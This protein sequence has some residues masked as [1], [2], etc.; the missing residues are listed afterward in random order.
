MPMR[1]RIPGRG[2]AT[3][4]L[5]VLIL[6]ASS[7]ATGLSP[8]D[9]PV[10]PPSHAAAKDGKKNERAKS[11][12]NN[13]QGKTDGKKKGKDKPRRG[14]RAK[15]SLDAERIAAENAQS[16]EAMECGGDLIA[17]R[18]DDRVYC[19]HGEDEAPPA[20]DA[21]TGEGTAGAAIAAESSAPAPRALCLDD[22]ISGPRIQ[23]IYVHR[24]DRPNRLQELLPT[25]RRLAAEMDLI[26]DQSARKTGGSL[27][28]RFVTDGNCRVDIQ[29]LSASPNAISGFGSLIQRLDD[30]GFDEL[31]RK[32]LMLVDASVY[33]G[34]GT[35]AGGNTA[36][37]PDTE[38]H[39]FTGYARVDLPCWDAGSMAHEISHTLGAVQNSAPNTSRGGHC[40]D[41][42]DVMCYS[43]EP[44]KPKMRFVCEDGAQDFRLDCGDNDY[45]AARPQP[46][47][48]LTRHWNMADSQY[49]TTTSGPTCVDA[50]YE[51]D[52]AFWYDYWK[53]PMPAFPIGH[54]QAHAFCS[55]TG[56]TDWALIHAKGG[57]T[58]LIE[59]TH[60]AP[61]VDTRMILY[62][63]FEEQRW[64]GMD[65][66]GTNDDR[67]EGDPSSAI[68]FT[69][70][71]DGSFLVGIAEVN[72]R[73]GFDQTYTLSVK[74][75][76]AVQAPPI[77]L[78]RKSAKPGTAFTVT[79]RNLDPA[80]TVAIWRQRNGQSVK[81]GDATA[82]EDGAASAT[83]TVSSGWAKGT[84]QIEGVT[85][86]RSAATA[87]FKV[88][89]NKKGKGKAKG[90]SKG[91]AGKHHKSKRGK[92]KH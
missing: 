63:G 17:L 44:F 76:G 38:A 86:N 85:D 48:Y 33:C 10:G 31:D 9:A 1:I 88:L 39:D 13:R 22:G 64:D 16:I 29:D 42:W 26:F 43:D 66:F 57:E 73:A 58:Y 59:T 87:S 37:N 72:E 23:L 2:A 36:D 55:E 79:V 77:S 82:G 6:L 84:H 21:Q 90:K 65:E 91:K 14:K 74:K 45:Y 52:D 51:P 61:G 68:S 8:A 35:Y 20:G 67:A 47:S 83:F 4:L 27:R 89:D 24:N 50:R 60:L 53:V 70:P 11:K 3:R 5:L 46:G 25:F 71:A 41:E 56:D 62:R 92:G 54:D 18:V 32:Y 28:V 80:E 75:T 40:I 69:A 7:A 12:D 49:L 15:A 78:S 19:T 30:A 34:V 81:L